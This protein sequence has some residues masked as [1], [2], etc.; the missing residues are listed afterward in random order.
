M[1]KKPVPESVTTPKVCTTTP[2]PVSLLRPKRGPPFS[3]SWEM[4]DEWEMINVSKRLNPL[5]GARSS[6]RSGRS[7]QV[8]ALP[9]SSAGRH[10]DA[11]GD[12]VD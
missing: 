3:P 10:L 11:L 5:R 1:H 4:G 12:V 9:S 8:N 6:Y 7:L 2:G